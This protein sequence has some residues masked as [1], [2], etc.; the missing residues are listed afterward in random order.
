MAEPDGKKVY[1]GDYTEALSNLI[2]AEIQ[3]GELIEFQVNSCGVQG[4]M[5]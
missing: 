3:D 4:E 1:S 2:L 5:A